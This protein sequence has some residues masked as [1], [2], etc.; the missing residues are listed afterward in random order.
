MQFKDYYEL[1]GVPRGA[2]ADEIKRAYRKLARKYHPD[3]SKEPQAE[4]RFKEIGEAYEVL[5]DAEKRAAYD[6]L[7]SR[8]RE[9]Q[10][11]RPPPDFGSGYEFSGGDS[12]AH[13]DEAAFSEFFESLFGAARR[14]GGHAGMTADHHARVD[15]DLEDAF[16]GAERTIKLQSPQTDASGR[17]RLVE[18]SLLVRIPAGVR[19]GQR[20][21]LAGQGA[22]G[23]GGKRGDLYLELR[24]RPHPAW[25]LVER[26]LYMELPLAPWE[27]ALGAKLQIAVPG[28]MVELQVPPGSQPGR[29]LRLKGRGL[30]GKP[31]GDL[32]VELRVVLPPA[33]D[34]KVAQAWR[35]M[36]SEVSFDPRAKAG[37]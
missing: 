10:D 18:R 30:P 3:V 25:R 11:F 13:D 22:P 6:R 1:L 33:G 17:V 15:I 14:G 37:N 31:P 19:E 16:G 5:G 28:G 36:A 27:A 23:P 29:K 34:P 4:E 24:F 32:Y 26:D 8:W 9:G 21:R 35:R 7:G 12:G 20:L 2:G